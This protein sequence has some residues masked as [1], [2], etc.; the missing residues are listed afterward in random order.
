[1]G[2]LGARGELGGAGGTWGKWGTWG[3]WEH[4]IKHA[5]AIELSSQVLKQRRYNTARIRL[6]HVPHLPHGVES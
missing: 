3:Q 4:G 6:L 2:N 5:S 1:M